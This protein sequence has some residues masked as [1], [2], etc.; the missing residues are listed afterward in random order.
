MSHIIGID[1]GTGMSA[2]SYF[3]SGEAKVIQNAEGSKTTPSVVSFN[4]D[5]T[6]TVGQVAKRQSI[7]NPK[8]VIHS[9]KRLIGKKYSQVKDLQKILAY[10]IAEGKNGMA[11]IKVRDKLVTPEEV[12]AAVLSKLKADAEA[13]LGET[14]TDAVI[15]V[16]AYFGDAERQAT[17]DA[18]RIAGLNVKRIINEP[19]AACLAYGLDKEGSKVIAVGDIGCGTS[20]ISILEYGDGVFEVLATNGDPLLGGDDIDEA[21]MKHVAEGFKSETGIDILKDNQAKARLKEACEKAKCEL[22]TAESTDINLPFITADASGPKHLMKSVTRAELEH[23]IEPIIR[24]FEAKVRQ[25]V[26]DS[27]KT[28]DE[29]SEIVMVGGTTRIPYIQEFFAKI[30]K[31]PVNKTVNPDEI[32]SQGA[33]I[34]GGV[35]SGDK[36]AGDVILLD[37]VSLTYGIE[38][39]GGVMTPMLE[40]GTTIP[41]KHT[42]KFSTASDNQPAVSIKVYQG[43]R[44]RAADNRLVGNFDLEGILP[45]PRGIPQIE[46]TFDISADGI[47]DISAKDLGTGRQNSIK[48]TG[49]SSLSKSDIERMVREAEENKAKDDE[50]KELQSLKNTADSLCFNVE[51]TLSE[52][53]SKVSQDT[54]SRLKDKLTACRAA[55]ESS[56]K[57]SIKTAVDELQK[58]L[59]A[60]GSEVYAQAQQQQATAEPTE[61]AAEETQERTQDSHGGETFDAESTVVD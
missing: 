32:V 41:V 21:L 13:A 37:V 46:V 48:V 10:E 20:D 28:L 8:T 53:E 57:E 59:A 47:L 31:K 43:E 38:T 18:G 1:L 52:I 19:T 49:T 6:K 15:T 45:A 58:V 50:F 11:C 54:L 44:S 40:R 25:C 16:P 12:G 24:P 3:E 34:Q 27:K 26:E 22:S 61:T 35:M 33:A 36:T 39:L 14:I 9:A 23:I 51:K 29:I 60:A 7:L 30:F 4:D 5:G 17:K 42:E 56:D 55:K 2:V